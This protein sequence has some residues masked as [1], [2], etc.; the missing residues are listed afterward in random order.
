[1]KQLQQT[2]FRTKLELLQKHLH[3]HHHATVDPRHWEEPLADLFVEAPQTQEPQ[4]GTFDDF[5]ALP[6]APTAT[7]SIRSESSK[8]Q[9]ATTLIWGSK[10]CE[11]CLRIQQPTAFDKGSS[12]VYQ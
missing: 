9:S 8:A 1:M 10:P 2:T 5:R 7:E 3:M 4:P 12:R 6:L 11:N